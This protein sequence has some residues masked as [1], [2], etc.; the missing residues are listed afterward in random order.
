M[1]RS[2]ESDLAWNTCV[3]GGKAFVVDTCEMI[4]TEVVG[5]SAIQKFDLDADG[6]DFGMG[7][8]TA[9][10]RTVPF[11]LQLRTRCRSHGKSEE[12]HEANSCCETTSYN[13]Q[14]TTEWDSPSPIQQLARLVYNPVV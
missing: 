5:P 7:V 13:L 12:L 8:R 11:T 4:G 10:S 3:L 9:I 14:A 2:V 1:R 6:A